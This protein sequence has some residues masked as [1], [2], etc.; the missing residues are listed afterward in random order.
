MRPHHFILPQPVVTPHG[1]GLWKVVEPYKFN[2][3]TVPAG[4]ITDFDSVPRLPIMFAVFKDRTIAAALIHDFLY[5]IGHDREESDRVFLRFM[6]AEGV[7]CR[8]AIPIF[9]AVRL[10]GWIFHGPKKS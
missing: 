5:S 10:F 6:V 8:Y 1:S 2:G 9:F 4:F 3:F 7:P